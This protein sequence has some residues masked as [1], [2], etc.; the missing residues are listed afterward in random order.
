M[1][2]SP[3]QK[4][5]FTNTIYSFKKHSIGHSDFNNIVDF[6]YFAFFVWDTPGTGCLMSKKPEPI[7]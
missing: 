3:E 7:V 6:N 5:Y 2:I 4:M 1:T